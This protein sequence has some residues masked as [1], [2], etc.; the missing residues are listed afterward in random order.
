MADL[1]LRIAGEAGHG[2]VSICDI[3][4]RSF[5]ECGLH[6]FTGQ[7]YMSRIRGG[8]NWVDIRIADTELFAV[9]EIADLL[10]ALTSEGYECLSLTLASDAITL[11]NI[12]QKED[13]STDPSCIDFLKIATD[14]GGNK[15]MINSIAAGGIFAILDF[16]LDILLGQI[17]E[18]FGSDKDGPGKMNV[19]CARAG[20][21]AMKQDL[22][23]S[24]GHKTPWSANKRRTGDRGFG[25]CICVKF[26]ASYPMS[27]STGTFTQMAKLSDE[28]GILIEQAEDEIAAI[29][30]ICGASYAGAMSM[31]TTTAVV[32]R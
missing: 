2:L 15:W 28:Y 24:H 20:F 11:Q 10:V 7:S 23:P 8:L 12:R 26:V 32:S 30:M 19:D 17:A 21:D 13:S 1:T 3:L 9:R 31:T 27:P 22:G 18:K 25:R 16:D 29:N 4:A 6:V 14:A 5:I